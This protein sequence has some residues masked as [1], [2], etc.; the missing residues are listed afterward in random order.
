MTYVIL[1]AY[2]GTGV[3]HS[4]HKKKSGEVFGKNAGE[5]TGRVE[6]SKEEIPGSKRSIYGDILAYSRLERENV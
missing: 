3:S 2:T 5:L 6:I 1:R 4:Q